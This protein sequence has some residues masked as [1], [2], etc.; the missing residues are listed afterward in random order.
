MRIAISPESPVRAGQEP[1][2]S[3]D[4]LGEDV[5]LQALRMHLNSFEY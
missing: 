3:E 2:E 1:A 4:T 5:M